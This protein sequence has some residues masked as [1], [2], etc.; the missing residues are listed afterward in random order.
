MMTQV[1]AHTQLDASALMTR[2]SGERRTKK[3]NRRDQAIAEQMAEDDSLTE[4]Q[5]A[6]IVDKAQ[7]ERR[8]AFLAARREDLIDDL[9]EE[10]EDW[11]EDQAAAEADEIIAEWIAERKANGG[12]CPNRDQE[13]DDDDD[14]E[15][16]DEDEDETNLAQVQQT[17]AERWA[18]KLEARIT[19]L[20]AEGMTTEEATAKA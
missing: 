9:L 10:N 8:E 6:D 11:T 16:D 4:E 17:C 13:E 3:A 1:Q 20:E 14:D 2:E 15:D 5:A 12:G 7:Q 19:E 18:A